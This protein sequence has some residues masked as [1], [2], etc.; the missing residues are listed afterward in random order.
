MLITNAYV[1]FYTY[2]N[3]YSNDL[4]DNGIKFDVKSFEL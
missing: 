4:L 3:I 2:F 1:V